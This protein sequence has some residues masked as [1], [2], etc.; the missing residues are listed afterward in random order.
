M[1]TS[2]QLVTAIAVSSR[3][4]AARTEPVPVGLQPRELPD[5]RA[6]ARRLA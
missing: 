1:A 5:L 6:T 4:T 2:R 3:L